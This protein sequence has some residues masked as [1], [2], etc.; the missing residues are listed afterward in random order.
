MWQWP[1]QRFNDTWL[2]S[3]KNIMMTTA[4]HLF[5]IFFFK[6]ILCVKPFFYDE[7]S[8]FYLWWTKKRT[9]LTESKTQ[10]KN[11]KKIIIN[12]IC[13]CTFNI[14]LN[15]TVR[16][17]RVKVFPKDLYKNLFN[18]SFFFCA[19]IWQWLNVHSFAM[20]GMA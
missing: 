7:S 11:K 18:Y 3:L 20:S 4:L 13:F 5:L 14:V 15:C 10:K 2:N 12:F 16:D 19:H 6:K 8:F 17:L 9:A 1:I